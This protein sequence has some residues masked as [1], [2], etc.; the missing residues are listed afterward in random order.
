MQLY[1]MRHGEAQ[2]FVE[3]GSRD[4]SQ[5]VLTAQGEIEAKMMANWLQKMQVSPEQVFVSPYVRA[6]QT[7]EIATN[8]MQTTITTLDFITPAGDAKQVHDF[9]DGW[10]SEQLAGLS[11]QPS[12]EHEQ[13]LLIISHMPLVSYL[14]AELTHSGNAPIFA[15]AGIA[16]IDYD[17][18]KMQGTLQRLVSP[19]E[20][21]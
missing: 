11:E 17:T 5:R 12:A 13:S 9:I 6:Q 21:C 10:C 2:N 15:T 1:I 4:D 20:L 14:V 8:A 7:C 3:Q 19:I 16:Q 18:K